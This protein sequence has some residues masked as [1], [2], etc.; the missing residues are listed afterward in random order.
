MAAAL[1][2]IRV[3]DYRSPDDFVIA[4]ENLSGEDLV[5]AKIQNQKHSRK[6]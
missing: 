6:D 3:I 2:Q 4:I 5:L 1:D